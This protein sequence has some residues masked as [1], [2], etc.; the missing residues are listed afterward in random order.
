M[1]A[2]VFMKYFRTKL[3]CVWLNAQCY[4][5]KSELNIMPADR[6]GFTASWTNQDMC[7][8]I[9]EQCYSLKNS[10]KTGVRSNHPKR[11]DDG[12][13]MQHLAL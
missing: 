12:H 3:K 7:F 8:V 5:K 9:S 10:L 13:G 1:R 11:H 4:N 6:D 2:C